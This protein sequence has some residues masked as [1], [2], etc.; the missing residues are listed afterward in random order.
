MTVEL[1]GDLEKQVT[2]AALPLDGAPRP[3]VIHDPPPSPT[4]NIARDRPERVERVDRLDRPARSPSRD[5]KP[6][7]RCQPNDQ[8]NPFDTSC[9][10]KAC[11]PCDPLGGA[12]GAPR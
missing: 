1:G 6:A 8:I 7:Q 11:P 10:G 12:K 3:P 9:D 2:L 4:P 5:A